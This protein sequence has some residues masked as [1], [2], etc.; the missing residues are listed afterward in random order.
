MASSRQRAD[1]PSLQPQKKAKAVAE[2][3]LHHRCCISGMSQIADSSVWL[4]IADPPY[5]IGVGGATWDK[6]DEYMAFVREWLTEACRILAPGGTLLFF[7]SP[8]KL[9][10]ARMNLLLNDELD[11]MEHIQSLS[12][13][14]SQGGD[15]RLENMK[16]Y[17]VRHE[18]VEWWKKKPGNPTFNASCAALKY[19]EAEKQVALAKGV[20]RVTAEALDRGRP[21]RTWFD[22]PRENSRSRERRF[23]KHPSMKPLELC[24]QLISVHSNHGDTIVVPFAGSGSELLTA[25]KLGR[26]AVGFETEKDYIEL[27]KKRFQGHDVTLT[28]ISYDDT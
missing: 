7:S 20:G 24:D 23:G 5:G 2:P 14:Y 12:W 27:M 16:C 15:A 13:N 26:E 21:P 22:V 11:D 9:W 4:V 1:S 3:I 17:A 6:S 28:T 10:G 19:T 8:C 25:A 18:I